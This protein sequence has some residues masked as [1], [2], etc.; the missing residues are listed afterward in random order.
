MEASIFNPGLDFHVKRDS[1]ICRYRSSSDEGERGETINNINVVEMVEMMAYSSR[2]RD[3]SL[4][5]RLGKR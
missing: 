5:K 2:F 1:K 3:Y 4:A